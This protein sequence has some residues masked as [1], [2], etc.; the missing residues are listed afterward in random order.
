MVFATSP[1]N[2]FKGDLKGTEGCIFNPSVPFL[3]CQNSS[4]IKKGC[5]EEHP[6]FC[7]REVSARSSDLDINRN[8]AE[9]AAGTSWASQSAQVRSLIE[10]VVQATVDVDAVVKGIAEVEIMHPGVAGL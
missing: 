2:R 9:S 6:F 8:E 7:C 1:A 5:S 3:Y 10:G 4:A